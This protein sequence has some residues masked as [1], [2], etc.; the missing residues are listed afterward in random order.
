M[1]RNVTIRGG[2]QPF[3]ERRTIGITRSVFSSISRIPGNF[4]SILS[5]TAARSSGPT[6]VAVAAKSSASGRCTQRWA[7][8][9]DSMSRA[10]MTSANRRREAGPVGRPMA[11]T[12]RF[13]SSKAA[14]TA[15]A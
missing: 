1:E 3:L 11:S 14:A 12:A 2:L 9:K 15:A 5:R 7:W 13:N 8:G 10:W 6:V 4:V